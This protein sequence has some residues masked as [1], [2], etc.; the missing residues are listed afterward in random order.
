MSKLEHK[1]L[2]TKPFHLTYSYYLSPD[3]NNKL[4]PSIPTLVF[5]HGFPDDAYMWAGAVPS[6]LKLSYPFVLVDILGLGGSSK[7]TDAANYNYR[8]QAN[9]IN[10]ILD[11]EKVP[12]NVIPIGHDWGSG[13][14]LRNDRSARPRLTCS[15]SY[16]AA[17]L[18]VSP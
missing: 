2:A 15:H 6:L 16:R 9:S 5:L 8:Q 17:L 12:N 1:T 4:D 10:Q 11:Q 7:P 18:L 3:F 14:S 13:D